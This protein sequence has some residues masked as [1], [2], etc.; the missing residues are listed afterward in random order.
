MPIVAIRLERISIYTYLTC[1]YMV[2]FLHMN[3]CAVCVG[4]CDGLCMWYVRVWVCVCVCVYVWVCNTH[5]RLTSYLEICM[6]TYAHAL[7]HI[8]NHSLTHTRTFN[9]PPQKNT[10]TRTH[11]HARNA[12]Y[13]SIHTHRW[14]AKCNAL[15]YA[16]VIPYAW[17][18]WELWHKVCNRAL[19]TH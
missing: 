3:V 10:H 14:K 4:G 8:L 12:M 7:T 18:F 13:F 16:R 1:M 11:A 9:P 5:N 15:R 2:T 6:E 17:E 19:Q